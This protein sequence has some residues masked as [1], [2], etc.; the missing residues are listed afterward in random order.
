MT[1]NQSAVEIDPTEFTILNSRSQPNAISSRVIVRNGTG[2]KY[3]KDFSS[4]GQKQVE[5]FGRLIYSALYSPPLDPPIRTPDLP[6]AGHGYGTQTLP[7]IFDF[8]N[9]ANGIP[10]VDSSKKNKR[11]LE[12]VQEK[13]D[14][15]ATLECLRKAQSLTNRFTGTHASSLGLHPAVY[16]YAA[17]GRHQPT[18][19]L[20]IA[21][22]LMDLEAEE[23]FI[24]FTKVRDKFESFLIDHK[25]F[26]NQLTVK[27]GSMAKGFRPLKEYYRY[28][29]DSFMSGH[30]D[31][32]VE[33]ELRTHDKYQ[34]LIKE[35]PVLTQQAKKFSRAVKQLTVIAE[36]FVPSVNLSIVLRPD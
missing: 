4:E 18:A 35:K 23:K 21:A 6:I 29:L 25:M 7:L 2:H 19:V 9:I 33:N 31:I 11:T 36:V 24:G 14:E 16:F 5:G 28:V 12:I 30:T 34:S 32:G 3:W 27:H 8:V 26:V 22:L 20:A 17:N 13:T 10:V 15:V 1:I